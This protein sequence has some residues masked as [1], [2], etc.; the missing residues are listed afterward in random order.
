MRSWFLADAA[1]YKLQIASELE[2]D[3]GKISRA[4]AMIMER[5]SIREKADREKRHLTSA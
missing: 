2:R 1:E 5:E 3:G 4:K